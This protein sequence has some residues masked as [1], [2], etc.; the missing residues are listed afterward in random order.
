LGVGHNPKLFGKRPLHTNRPCTERRELDPTTL[1]V[2]YD[3][4]GMQPFAQVS[5]RNTK[6]TA[7]FPLSNDFAAPM[8]LERIKVA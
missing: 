6:A 1:L 5:E 3:L 8:D 4:D 2:G 7:V